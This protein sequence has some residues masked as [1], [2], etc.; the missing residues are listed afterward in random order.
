[1]DGTAVRAFAAAGGKGIV[2]AGLGSG[3][4]PRAFLDAL[5]KA[6]E[7]GVPV[8][9]ASQAGSGRVMARRTFV[10]RGFIVADNLLPRKARILLMLALTQ[11]RDAAELRRIFGTY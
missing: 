3:S 8:V 5:S 9:V 4:A 7:S 1:M 11:T 10:E 2:A 6:A